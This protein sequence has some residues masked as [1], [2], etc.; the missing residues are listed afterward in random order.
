MNTLNVKKDTLT[1]KIIELTLEKNNTVEQFETTKKN[2]ITQYK[3]IE[4]KI[5]DEFKIK[6]ELLN[7]KKKENQNKEKTYHNL[8]MH[9]EKKK[10]LESEVALFLKQEITPKLKK[11]IYGLYDN[12]KKITE[13]DFLLKNEKLILDS[14]QIEL[15]NK[16]IVIE[17]K[18]KELID[19]EKKTH[20]I[21]NYISLL[22]EQINQDKKELTNL[23]EKI[24]E[25]EGP[26]K[27]KSNLAHILSKNNL[28][29][30]LIE[31][32]IPIIEEEANTILQKLTNGSSK[33][34]IESIKDLKS[35][36]IKET[37]DI[38][39]ADHIGI[40][41][42]EFFSGGESFR[43]DLAL[44]IALVK[45]LA[46]KSGHYIKTFII[47]EGFGSQDSQSLEI[48][49]DT[50]YMLQ[51]EFDLIIIISHLNDM[52]EQFPIQ[53]HIEKTIKGSTIKQL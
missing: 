12:K 48:M 51:N 31:E 33:I 1:K 21:H 50:L 44:R 3:S 30:A 37:L 11:T 35:G 4:K 28:Q 9:I 41:Y 40:R 26:L 52:K 13:L 49:I 7:E 2:I 42:Y 46:Q 18:N 43:I 27:I 34:Y 5:I 29:A 17:K 47:D 36:S 32:A 20:E 23:Q 22:K 45:L 15:V 38:K 19:L 6:I 8:S 53:F 24:K 39:I 10:F 16:K 14:Q 25:K